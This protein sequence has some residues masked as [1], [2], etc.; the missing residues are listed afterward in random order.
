VRKPPV[1][2][3]PE[4]AREKRSRG[5]WRRFRERRTRRRRRDAAVKLP[6]VWE[7]R[8]DVQLCHVGI[9]EEWLEESPSQ[10]QEHQQRLLG[11]LESL[12]IEMSDAYLYLEPSVQRQVCKEEAGKLLFRQYGI[13]AQKELLE[14]YWNEW[15][16]RRAPGKYSRLVVV[17]EPE[18]FSRLREL[19]FVLAE[20]RNEMTLLFSGVSG[21]EESVAFVEQVID[22]AEDLSYEYGLVLRHGM[23]VQQF[24]E[25]E[26]AG[27]EGLLAVDLQEEAKLL[28]GLLD[29]RR[30]CP[31]V[32]LDGLPTPEKA[33]YVSRRATGAIQYYCI[34]EKWSNYSAVQ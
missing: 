16:V 2:I 34:A 17:L 4:K 1:D 20:G 3:Q 9:P 32:Y 22:F 24:A 13:L 14:E 19:L 15:L 28:V 30:S 8:D 5:I 11:Y 21:E 10:P 7:E 12:L 33:K 25:R 23:S 27:Q 29:A 31:V 18:R 6:V 26:R